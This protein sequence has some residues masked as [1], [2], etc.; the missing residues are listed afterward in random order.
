MSSI[1][2]GLVKTTNLTVT[3][4]QSGAVQ[5]TNF[6]TTNVNTQNVN[7]TG[8]IVSGGP[9]HNG[10]SDYL[11]NTRSQVQAILDNVVNTY[12]GGNG[13]PNM[14]AAYCNGK[15]ATVE[16]V[17][18]GKQSNGSAVPSNPYYRMASNSKV[19]AAVASAKLMAEGWINMDT[20]I[21][22][23]L[24]NGWFDSSNVAHGDMIPDSCGNVLFDTSSNGQ[25]FYKKPWLSANR[26]I[27]D[28]VGANGIPLT[29]AT[30]LNANGDI[31][32]AS[33]NIATIRERT[34]Q[35]AW[36]EWG[37]TQKPPVAGNC[38]N[39]TVGMCLD[40]TCGLSY[41]YYTFGKFCNLPLVSGDI[42]T[43][44]RT[45]K[46]GYSD[47]LTS[48]ATG[49]PGSSYPDASLNF[50]NNPANA[51]RLLV[52]ASGNGTYTSDN[53]LSLLST[54]PVSN[55]PGLF[56]S[57]GRGMDLLGMFLDQVIKQTPAFSAYLDIIDYVQKTILIPIGITDSWVMGGQSAAPA[58]CKTR[59]I[60][61]SVTRGQNALGGNGK[62]IPHG[63]VDTSNAS[64]RSILGVPVAKYGYTDA[65]GWAYTGY[66]DA[67]NNQ[68]TVFMDDVPN[69]TET[70][71]MNNIYQQTVRDPTIKHVG[72]MGSAWCMSIG[73]MAKLLRFVY[74]QGFDVVSKTR[75]IPK[76][77]FTY[78]HQTTNNES[79]G[80]IGISDP[81]HFF[82]EAPIEVSY[83]YGYPMAWSFGGMQFIE[84]GSIGYKSPTIAGYGTYINTASLYPF[85]PGGRAW[86]GVYNT[87][88]YIDPD[89]GNV[90]VF[91]MSQP[92]WAGAMPSV[93]EYNK[94]Y[95]KAI[96]PGPI[97]TI[98]GNN[99]PYAM[100]R[101]VTIINGQPN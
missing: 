93:F 50:V 60:S 81:A 26:K 14:F 49:Q 53:Y 34:M 16:T 9:V 23:F 12:L 94:T 66:F 45:R 98:S 38:P 80:N 59:L 24:G 1:S 4:T 22:A 42:A 55:L 6:N 71:G 84:L 89:S 52:D 51:P 54:Q 31:L 41:D 10:A 33:G 101:L 92:A 5:A 72:Q 63:L 11:P 91:G 44:A 65:S 56:S 8:Q 62:Q 28:V 40:H 2:A 96:D 68:L 27:I 13:T 57:Y 87:G 86:A 78:I 36:T 19:I 73:S 43:Y 75:I 25:K 35:Q 21:A 95:V 18:S 74:N 90:I 48:Y 97:K 70:I 58:D 88:W 20:P 100:S 37:A 83:T 30:T 82:T 79:N 15:D 76:S 69:D 29:G 67:S 47:Y 39:I 85:A 32:D 99:Q 7:A 17:V 61:A 46:Y 64:L 3:G 77:A